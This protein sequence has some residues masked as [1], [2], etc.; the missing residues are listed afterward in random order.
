MKGIKIGLAIAAVALLTIGSS[1]AAFA[2]HSGGVAECAGCHNMHSPKAGG[3]ALLVGGDQSSTCLSCHMHA[4]DTGP[5]SYHIAT[6]DAD[7]P[8]GTAPKQRTP[9]GDFGWVKKTYNFLLRGTPTTETGDSHGHNIVA[10]DFGFTADGTNATAPGGTF[11]SAQ[12]GCNSCHDPHSKQR[13]LTDGSIVST[14]APIVGSGS[15]D[16]STG[17]SAA[18]PIPAGQAVGVYRLLAGNGYTKGAA[19]YTGVP[20][21]VAPQ[22]YNRT[23]AAT[24]TRV[25]YGVGTGAGKVTWSQWCSTCHNS[26]HST[27]NYVHPVDTAMST[28][29]KNNYN[30]YVSSGKMDGAAASAYLSLTPFAENTSDYTVL[31]GHAKNDGSQLGGPT[32]GDQVACISCHRSHATAFPEML[33]WQ[34][35][36][37][38]I[39]AAKADGTTPVWPNLADTPNSSG[40]RGRATEAEQM[41]GYYDRPATVFGVNQRVLCNKC[42]AKD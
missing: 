14:G 26:M 24:Q 29:I 37:E 31:G 3:T 40:Y 17:N 27:G 6:A 35:E 34:S 8:A 41:A 25:A 36:Y 38:F 28:G 9:G 23:E 21:A 32:D 2:F 42:H 5:S 19:S 4:G 13:R 10:A 39:T 7:M 15:Y 20:V 16:S 33:R 1:G 11:V 30:A 12:L 18:K 22:T